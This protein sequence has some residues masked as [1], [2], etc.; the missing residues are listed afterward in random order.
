MTAVIDV[1][2]LSTVCDHLHKVHAA[3]ERV[4]IKSV[5]RRKFECYDDADT[6]GT[7]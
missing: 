4:I 1:M 3:H 7:K 2:R 5:A 6:L